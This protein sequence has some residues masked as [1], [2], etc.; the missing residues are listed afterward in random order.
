MAATLPCLQVRMEWNVAPPKG[1]NW[2]ILMLIFMLVEIAVLLDIERQ[3]VNATM[4]L[5]FAGLGILALLQFVGIALVTAGRYRVGGVLQVAASAVHALDLIGMI[6]VVGSIKAY[7]Y[8]ERLAM[9]RPGVTAGLPVHP[10]VVRDRPRR[11]KAKLWG[12]CT[13]C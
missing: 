9:S 1:L 2:A 3:Y 13:S 11:T 10:A 4:E 5:F 12:K 8:P 6:G 7:R